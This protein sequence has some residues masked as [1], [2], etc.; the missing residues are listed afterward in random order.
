MSTGAAGPLCVLVGAPGAGKTKVGRLLAAEVGVEFRDTDQDIAATAGKSVSDIFVEDGEAAFRR[1]EADSVALALAEH[2]GVLS[3]GGGAVMNPGTRDLLLTQRVVWLRV[4]LAVAARRTGM[5]STPRPLLMVN[6]RG[7]LK[8]LL[9]E[10]DPR[11]AEVARLTVDADVDDLTG[12]VA[13][14]REWLVG[15]GLVDPVAPDDP[16]Q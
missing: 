10:R 6:L 9:D 4:S 8:A 7:T 3:L 2:S 13:Q 5:S 11:Y 14:I 15:Q 1:L 16:R 12:K